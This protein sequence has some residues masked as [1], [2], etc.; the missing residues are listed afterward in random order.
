MKS[1][2]QIH[3]SHTRNIEEILSILA[4]HNLQP[5]A[6]IILE[7]S[8]VY[9]FIDGKVFGID[10]NAWVLNEQIR[11]NDSEPNRV[12]KW[13]N[14]F[15]ELMCPTFDHSSYIGIVIRGVSCTDEHAQTLDGI[16][17]GGSRQWTKK[18]NVDCIF[19][20]FLYGITPVKV[21]LV[22]F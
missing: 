21:F 8:T 18:A 10:G 3:P 12:P 6:G 19:V 2:I 4:E 20:I 14:Y 7:Y 1:I 13:N 9:G 11:F 15:S 17:F 16:D 5:V 22:K